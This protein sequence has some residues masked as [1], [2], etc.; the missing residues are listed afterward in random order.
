MTSKTTKTSTKF[1]KFEGTGFRED[2]RE[3]DILVNGERVGTI[4]AVMQNRGSMMHPEWR[5]GQ[6][7]LELFGED[8]EVY[9]SQEILVLD[10]KGALIRSVAHAKRKAKGWIAANVAA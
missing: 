6:Y 5:V 9:A 7:D 4:T 2:D 1:G 8:G 10:A 3:A